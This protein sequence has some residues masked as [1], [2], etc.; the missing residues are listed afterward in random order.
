[1]TC[2]FYNVNL[3]SWYVFFCSFFDVHKAM[4]PEIRS[5]AEIYG[6]IYSGALKGIPISGVG[7]DLK[8]PLFTLTIYFLCPP[9]WNSGV[10]SFCPV[11]Q[12]L[13]GKN[14]ILGYRVKHN[15]GDS[16]V[17]LGGVKW[18]SLNLQKEL[19][20]SEYYVWSSENQILTRLVYRKYN[21]YR[22]TS[23]SLRAGYGHYMGL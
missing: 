18:R 16:S 8:N 3:F 15:K 19:F 14:F 2:H 11:C 9:E 5:S 20:F 17:A 23:C 22:L 4:L 12:W 21:F 13:C 1:M 7:R 6:K 10:F